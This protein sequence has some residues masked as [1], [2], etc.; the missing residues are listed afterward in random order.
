MVELEEK[1]RSGGIL[2]RTL[3]IFFD[4]SVAHLKFSI[5]FMFVE[6]LQ[7]IGLLD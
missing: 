1:K 7:F 4:V 3:L 2:E 5:S 6:S